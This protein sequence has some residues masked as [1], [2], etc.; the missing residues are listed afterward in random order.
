MSEGVNP[1]GPGAIAVV[2]DGYLAD[3]DGWKGID[4]I[5]KPVPKVVKQVK[6]AIAAGRDVRILMEGRMFGSYIDKAEGR[7]AV[8]FIDKWTAEVFGRALPVMTFA[9]S[10]VSE[11]WGNED[12][13]RAA[14]FLEAA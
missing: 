7:H 8:A 3:F 12:F 9:D 1:T 2:L 5:G 11:I 13:A 10:S 4:H 14:H 6:A